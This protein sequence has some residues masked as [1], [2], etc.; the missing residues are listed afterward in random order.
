M[1]F[2]WQ[3]IEELATLD[4]RPPC[5]REPPEHPLYVLHRDE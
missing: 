5:L 3:H 4:I 1:Y 2:S